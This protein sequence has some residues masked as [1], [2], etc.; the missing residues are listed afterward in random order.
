MPPSSFRPK[1]KGNSSAFRGKI[2]NRF[3]DPQSH[4]RKKGE[5]SGSSRGHTQWKIKGGISLNKSNSARFKNSYFKKNVSDYIGMAH[6]EKVNVKVKLARMETT[7]GLTMCFQGSISFDKESGRKANKWLQKKS[8]GGEASEE[9]AVVRSSFEN[10]KSYHAF[11][12]KSGSRFSDSQS[13]LAAAN[14]IDE[15]QTMTVYPEWKPEKG[16]PVSTNPR[17]KQGI[18]KNAA[19]DSIGLAH[20]PNPSKGGFKISSTTRMTASWAKLTGMDPE[21]GS[22]SFMRSKVPTSFKPVTNRRPSS[23]FAGKTGTRFKD[24]SS[25]L[26]RAS[27]GNQRGEMMNHRN[28]NPKGGVAIKMNASNKDRF[29]G[30]GS[31]Y[32]K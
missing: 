13:H 8:N 27:K 5:S 26:T 20:N 7:L 12:G 31:I 24:P 18:Y 17:F 10:K 21:E 3:N 19:T 23:A 2:G 4:L 29:S 14:K 15:R 32:S 25:Y 1:S 11:S 16:V 22:K 6:K 30:P 28:W 9:A